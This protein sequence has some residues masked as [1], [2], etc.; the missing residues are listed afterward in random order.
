MNRNLLVTLIVISVIAAAAGG[1][2]F[3]NRSQ[4]APVVNQSQEVSTSPASSSEKIALK[5]LMNI[6]GSQKC[7]FSD[8]ENES[9]GVIYISDRKMRGEFNAKGGEKNNMTYMVND[10]KDIYIW[11]DD[12]TTGFKTSLQAVEQMSQQQGMTGVNQTVDLNRPVDYSCENWI[13]DETK[14]AV[15]VEVKFQDTG[16]LMKNLPQV[17]QS[18]NPQA[19][20]SSAACAACNN[21]QGEERDQCRTALKCN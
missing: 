4:S 12:Q 16:A 19:S 2:L 1:Y 11:M 7:Q 13:K 10:G 20:V 14:F 6:S 18:A 5:D 21:L 8:K 15:P 17:V 3:M 9:N